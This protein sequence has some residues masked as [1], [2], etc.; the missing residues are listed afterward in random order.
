MRY[1][2]YLVKL[3]PPMVAT[4][5]PRATAL[6]E[7]TPMTVSAAWLDRLRTQENSR[8][9]RMLKRT[10]AQSG[11]ARPRMEPM[12]IPVKAEWPRA[13]EKKQGV[14]HKVPVEHFKGKHIPES[15]P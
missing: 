9:K 2:L 1:L 4:K 15:I 8:E 5:M 12:A 6:L 7:K 10:A 14:L 13:S 11:A 3:P